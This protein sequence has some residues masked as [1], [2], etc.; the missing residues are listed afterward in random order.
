MMS[1]VGLTSAGG[2]S[3]PTFWAFLVLALVLLQIPWS[4]VVMLAG[5]KMMRMESYGLALVGAGLALLPI[6]P[7]AIVTMPVGIWALVMLSSSEVR[8]AFRQK[9]AGQSYR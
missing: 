7:A 9:A 6:G 3:T 5:M 4:L 2:G 8:E 1:M